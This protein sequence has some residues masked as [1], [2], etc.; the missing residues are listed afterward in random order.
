MKPAQSLLFAAAC[1]MFFIL[2]STGKAAIYT[3]NNT[4]ADALLS[5]ASPTLNFGGAG[6]LAIAPA[7]S[8]KGEFD[9]VIMFNT[10]GAVSQFNTTYGA[11]NWAIT[12]FTLSLA[13][14]F[15]ANGAIPNNNLLNT[16]SG[17]NFGIDWLSY[18]SWVEGNGGGMGVANGAVSFNSIST[19]FSAGSDSLGTYLYTPPGNNVYASYSLPLDAGLVSDAAAGG[20]VSLYFYAADTQVSYLFNSKEFASNHPELTITATPVPEPTSAAL[21]AASLGGFLFS[22]RQKWKK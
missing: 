22:F 13:S 5:G 7:S 19:L 9:S 4:T 15:G 18:D 3:I 14:N 11:G 8:A 1:G 17:G 10:A 6:T 20:A 21:L 16:V 12:G 2:P